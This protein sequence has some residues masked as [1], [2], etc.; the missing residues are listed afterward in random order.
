[1]SIDNGCYLYRSCTDCELADCL[2]NKQKLKIERL[3]AEK[4]DWKQRYNSERNRYTD[5]CSASSEC[6]KKKNDH[7]A[8]LQKQ[9]DEL[10]ERLHWIWLLGVDYDGFE[11]SESLKGLID[12]MIELTQ[13]ESKDFVEYQQSKDDLRKTE[14]KYSIEVEE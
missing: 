4:N 14:N 5:L 2:V 7:I 8:E 10:K 1:M 9:V 3:K 11:K 6:I 12:E 13:I